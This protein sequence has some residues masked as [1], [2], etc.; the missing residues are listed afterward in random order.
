METPLRFAFLPSLRN[1][2]VTEAC[3]P[4]PS[5]TPR[6]P[7]VT[8]C[9]GLRLTRSTPLGLVL[10]PLSRCR[11]VLTYLHVNTNLDKP[12]RA[13]FYEI[14]NLDKSVLT[15]F[16]EITNLDKSVQAPFYELTNLDKSVRASF[17]ELTNLD[18]PV[19]APFY[20]LTNLDKSVR[21]SF[22]ELTNLDKS[23]RAPFYEITNLDKSVRASFY[24]ITNSDK[25][26]QAP[27]YEITN[28]NKPVRAPFYEITNLDKSVR[29]PFY[30]ITNFDKSVRVPFYEITNLMEGHFLTAAL[31]LSGC[32]EE[33]LSKGLDTACL[34]FPEVSGPKRLHLYNKDSLCCEIQCTAC[35]KQPT[36]CIAVKISLHAEP[37][38]RSQTSQQED[39][40]SACQLPEKNRRSGCRAVEKRLPDRRSSSDFI[41]SVPE[42][43]A[44][45]PWRLKTPQPE[46]DP[47]L[48]AGNRRTTVPA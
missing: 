11:S 40:R 1:P 33:V 46:E 41:L 3:S 20:E 30:E 14:T 32:G 9:R 48:S 29:A 39:R 12:V 26:V 19:R 2:P 22:Y 17:Y 47:C 16:Y 13:P 25:F 4:A 21:A 27:F 28:L 15:P 31:L 10:R 34:L 6:A 36:A 35:Q 8:R 24:D 38:R 44:S 5:Q 18:K 45:S 7:A 37:E 23:V 42:G 43:H